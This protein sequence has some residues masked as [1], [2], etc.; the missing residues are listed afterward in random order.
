[1]DVKIDNLGAFAVAKVTGD[2]RAD[3]AERF[4]E[5]LDEYASGAGSPLAVDLSD[6]ATMDSSGLAALIQLTS[7]ARLSQGRVV[8]IAP[9]PFVSGILNVT[10]LDQ[11]FEICASLEEAEQRLA[12]G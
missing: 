3:T 1:V 7:R 11:W 4:A 6:V 9:S 8:L 12:A 2:L 10:R 5:E